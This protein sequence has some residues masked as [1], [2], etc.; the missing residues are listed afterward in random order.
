MLS[1]FDAFSKGIFYAGNVF[2]V[3]FDIVLT[4]TT[5]EQANEKNLL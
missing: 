1:C 4:D 5:R 3:I 2:F